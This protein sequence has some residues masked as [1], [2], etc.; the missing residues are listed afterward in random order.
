MVREYTTIF[1]VSECSSNIPPFTFGLQEVMY[2]E[3]LLLLM[4]IPLKS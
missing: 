3:N 4:E 1:G 2:I